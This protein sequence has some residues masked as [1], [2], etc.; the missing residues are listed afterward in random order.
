MRDLVLVALAALSAGCGHE[1]GEEMVCS[2]AERTG[3]YLVTVTTTSGNCGSLPQYYV[4]GAQQ[5]SP[6][7]PLC[8]TEYESFSPNGCKRESTATCTAADLG[9]RIVE[10]Y[11]MRQEDEGGEHLTETLTMTATVIATGATRCRGTYDIEYVKQ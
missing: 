7:G 4:D 1:R 8:L 11:V 6:A 5:L 9:F 3:T 2:A 10:R